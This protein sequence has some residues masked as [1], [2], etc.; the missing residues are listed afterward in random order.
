MKIIFISLCSLFIVLNISKKAVA[1][2]VCP[3]QQQLRESNSVGMAE[4]FIEGLA[5]S[6]DELYREACQSLSE[7]GPI[8][9]RNEDGTMLLNPLSLTDD[10]R[11]T[12]P[13][14]M[15]ERMVNHRNFKSNIVPLFHEMKQV[16]IEKLQEMP[17]SS[18][19]KRAIHNISKI[20]IQVLNRERCERPG[21]PA[22]VASFD[23]GNNSVYIC[24]LMSHATAYS[25]MSILSHEIGHAL[26]TCEADVPGET[27]EAYPFA[28]YHQCMS[29]GQDACPRNYDNEDNERF[30]DYVSARISKWMFEKNPERTQMRG[31]QRFGTFIGYRML[32][33]EE[34]NPH[35]SI[36]E[37]LRNL[38]THLGCNPTGQMT[39]DDAEIKQCL[40][41]F[42]NE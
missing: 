22:V 11:R 12:N 24:P 7:S 10:Y 4:E 39:N 2:G 41:L 42:T 40:D 27:P 36:A 21:R 26:D 32:G 19:R 29:P 31:Q 8:V 37:S 13:E 1:N 6:C 38:S 18:F 25:L 5:P 3:G 16:V 34:G 9:S 33:C 15:Q 20:G 23:H 14:L 17:K 35:M 30:A 28:D